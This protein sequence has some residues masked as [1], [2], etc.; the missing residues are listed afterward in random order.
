MPAK[1]PAGRKPR[2]T[3]KRP[4][5]QKRRTV[6]QGRKK[7]RRK[8]KVN[9]NPLL[10]VAIAA[11]VVFLL[12]I[13]PFRRTGTRDNTSGATVPDIPFSAFGIDISH[14][15]SGPILWDSLMV[16]TDR[17]GR[18]IRDLQSARHTRPV[19]F[20]FIKATEGAAMRD[21]K[22]KTL[23]AEAGEHDI[24]RG[25]YHFFRSS[26]DGAVQARNFIA[27]VGDLRHSDLPPVLD[28]ETIHRGCS[29]KALNERALVWLKNVEEH[30]RRTPIVYTS[31]DFAKNVLSKE[32]T[33]NY[34]I[35][36]AHYKAERP[37]FQD[38]EYWQFTDKALVYGIQEPVDLNVRR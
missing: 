16:L 8:K 20:V 13:L 21:P 3:S 11:A 17:E 26:K 22:F 29:H 25:A 14:N 34:P 6:P 15:N 36:I 1:A 27:T 35:W 12:I 4:A 30:Y 9:I 32:I 31:D 18:T 7:S 33:D 37:V 19:K 23:W 10:A 5:P 28:I 38:W 2:T 24:K